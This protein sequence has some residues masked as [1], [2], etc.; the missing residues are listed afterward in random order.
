MKFLNYFALLFVFSLGLYAQKPIKLTLQECVEMAYEKNISIKQSELD[1]D[2]ASIDKADALGNFLPNFN[3]QGSHSWNVGLNQNITTGLLENQTTQFSSMGFSLGVDIYNGSQNVNRMHRANLT[4][5]AR[6]YQLDDIK[7]NV[8]LLVVNAYLQVL[9]NKE[10]L[11]IQ[12]QQTQVSKEELE[13][14]RSLVEAG[15]LIKGDLYEIEANYASQEQALIQAE[16]AL[17][18]TRINLAQLLLITDYENFDIADEEFEVPFSEIMQQSQK[19]IFTKALSFRNDV[20]L[21]ETN[22]S[23][24]EKDVAISK[25]N[26]LPSIRGFYSYNTRVSYSDRLVPDGSGFAVAPP[27]PFADQLWINDGQNFGLQLS[28]PILNGFSTKNNVKRS[29]VNLLR[30]TNQLEQ[31]KLDLETNINQ[32]YNDAKGAYK[33]YEATNRTLASR[34]EAYENAQ[35]RFNLGVINSFDFVQVKQRYEAAV[36]NFLRAK[37]DYIFKLKVVEL[38][39]GIPIVS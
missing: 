9:F 38:Y 39:F 12:E 3:A 17:L 15:T 26:L 23:I 34:K 10:L 35:E 14:T 37:Y 6:Q 29:R 5:L 21:A 22:V 33:F 31:Q 7:E 1:L 28:V 27:L 18:L 4:L 8:S 24:A 11:T 25:G 36:S 20:K 13:R 16:N 32:A 19:A 30:V 2:N